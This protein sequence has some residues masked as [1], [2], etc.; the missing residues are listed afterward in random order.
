MTYPLGNSC[1]TAEHNEFEL[2]LL[3]HKIYIYI[4]LDLSSGHTSGL[5]KGK[6]LFRGVGIAS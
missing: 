4:Y 1:S 5:S 3:D 2:K 6:M